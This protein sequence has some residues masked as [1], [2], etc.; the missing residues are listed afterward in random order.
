[1]SISRIAA[2]IGV[3]AAFILASLGTAAGEDKLVGTYGEVR[4]VLAFKLSDAALQKI[5]PEG[6][7]AVPVAAGPAQ[8]ANLN[9]NVLDWVTVT[10]PDGKPGEGLRITAIAVPARKKGTEVGGAMVVAGL[11]SGPSY[12]PGA[13]GN[14]GLAKAA[15]ERRVR[16]DPAGAS[17]AEEAWEFIG[18]GGDK[19]QLQLKYTAGVPT[20]SKAEFKVYSAVKPDFYRIYRLDTAADVVRSTATGV[21]RVQAISFTASGPK[22]SAIFDGKEQLVSITSLPFYSRQVFLP[23]GMEQPKF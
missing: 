20:R 19:I 2:R 6:W 12:V 17:A 5:L 22:L 7:E 9:L 4:T 13:Y 3:A 1:M 10:K 15:M 16:T 11:V 18:D 23:D 21:D 14:F 8:G